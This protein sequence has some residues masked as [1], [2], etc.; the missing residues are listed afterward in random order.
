MRHQTQFLCFMGFLDHGQ[1]DAFKVMAYDAEDAAAIAAEKYDWET[2]EY[3]LAGG[4]Y[5]DP[6][7]YV[8]ESQGDFFPYKIEVDTRP[9]YTATPTPEEKDDG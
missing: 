8:A 3:P 9:S 2:A 1:E 5:D 4:L 6:V 7:I